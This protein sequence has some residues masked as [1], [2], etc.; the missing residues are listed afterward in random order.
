M[1]TSP[2]QSCVRQSLSSALGG[3]SYVK[4]EDESSQDSFRHKIYDHV[5]IRSQDKVI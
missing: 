3:G 5:A 2:K 1:A 4:T